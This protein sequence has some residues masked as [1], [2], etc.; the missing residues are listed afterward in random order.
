[1]FDSSVLRGTPLD[2]PP[3]TCYQGMVRHS[4]CFSARTYVYILVAALVYVYTF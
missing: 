4:V 3:W 2:V 1:M